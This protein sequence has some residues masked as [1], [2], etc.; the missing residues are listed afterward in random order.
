M[1]I[2]QIYTRK[3]ISLDKTS[4]SQLKIVKIVDIYRKAF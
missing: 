2:G 1:N 3:D 4:D